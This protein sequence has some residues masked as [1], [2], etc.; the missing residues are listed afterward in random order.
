MS[1]IVLPFVARER[2]MPPERVKGSPLGTMGGGGP[3]HNAIVLMLMLMLLFPR[4]PPPTY[5]GGIDSPGSGKKNVG[6]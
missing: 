3:L 6:G 4:R 2:G 1:W 5:T